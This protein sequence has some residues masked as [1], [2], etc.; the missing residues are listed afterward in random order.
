MKRRFLRWIA[1]A[2]PLQAV[3]CVAQITPHPWV[4]VGPRGDIGELGTQ[5]RVRSIQIVPSGGDFKLFVGGSSGGLWRAF[6]SQGPVWANLGRLLPNPSVAAFAVHPSNADDIL[7]GTGDWQHYDLGDGLYHTDDGGATWSKVPFV[8][9]KHCFQI[10]YPDPGNPNLILAATDIGLL[11]TTSGVNGPWVQRLTGA[12]TD[13]VPHPTNP[14]ILYCAVMGSGVWRTLDGGASWQPMNP[15][16]PAFVAA[17]VGLAALAICRSAPDNLVFVYETMNTGI[18]SN[19]W[20]TTTAG[21]NWSAATVPTSPHPEGPGQAQHALSVAIRPTDPQ[22]IFLGANELWV[23]YDRGQNWTTVPKAID[24]HQDHTRLLFSPVTGDDTLWICSDGGVFQWRLT[25]PQSTSWNGPANGL[26]SLNL[27]QHADMDAIRDL[28]VVGNQDTGGAASTT[29]GGQ[30]TGFR[31]C[32]IYAVAITGDRSSFFE[33]ESYWS[34]NAEGS[35]VA[36]AF[37]SSSEEDKSYPGNPLQPVLFY[38]RFE[39]RVYSLT[40]S[41]ATLVARYVS[42]TSW[43][44]VLQLP[45]G[46]GALTGDRLNGQTLFAWGSAPGVL[47]VLK[48]NGGNWVVARSSPIGTTNIQAVFA[49]TERVGESWALIQGPPVVL[50]T[51]DDWQTWDTNASGNLNALRGSAAPQAMAVMPFNPRVMF[52]TTD[53]GVFVTENGGA[54]WQP[55]QDQLPVVQIRRL[56]YVVDAHHTGQDKL[57]AATYG[58][59]TFERLIP[60]PPLVYV[61]QRNFK[62]FPDGTF[63]HPFPFLNQGLAATPSSGML[64]L[65]GM[66]TYAAPAVLSQRLTL[67]AYEAPAR[68]GR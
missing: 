50:H 18:V 26:T 33:V 22:T 20:V 17:N 19:I 39:D 64:A 28:R 32:D 24:R 66:T 36:R 54:S 49:S 59:G 61:D 11:R 25:D 6:G 58:R 55:F 8:L 42:G 57:V 1:M 4:S 14:A 40:R 51:T 3:L 31:C 52:V 12:V 63:E 44:P 27:M 48:N 46:T 53:K 16:S 2:A 62:L 30:W 68:L 65:N 10:L 21:Q 47:T 45:A 35:V 34:I 13:L 9:P 5:G 56:R 15:S 29:G 41:N 38:N 7:V 37:G 23:S 60:R 67:T 43:V